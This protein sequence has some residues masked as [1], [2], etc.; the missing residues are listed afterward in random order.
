MSWHMVYRNLYH[1]VGRGYIHALLYGAYYRK[2]FLFVKQAVSNLSLRGGHKAQRPTWQS[3]GTMF[4]SA[5]QFDRSYQE[6]ATSLR[7]SQWQI[8]NTQHYQKGRY[9]FLYT[10]IAHSEQTLWNG[11][12][13]KCCDLKTAVPSVPPFRILHNRMAELIMFR[14]SVQKSITGI[15]QTSL[16]RYGFYSCIIV[17]NLVW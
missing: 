10:S 6:I 16:Y 5:V 2:V 17:Y 1:S 15:Q 14:H 12:V 8:R 4:V 11:R 7:S 3:P 13:Y 9:L